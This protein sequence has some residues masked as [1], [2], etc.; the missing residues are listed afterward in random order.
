MHVFGHNIL[1]YALLAA[2]LRRRCLRHMERRCAPPSRRPSPQTRRLATSRRSTSCSVRS[3][4]ETFEL[5][6]GLVCGRQP[7]CCWRC[8]SPACG[9]ARRCCCR[10]PQFSLARLL[11]RH[12]PPHDHARLDQQHSTSG[13][14]P[15]H[16]RSA[17]C[18]R[19]SAAGARRAKPPSWTRC[20]NS[21][22]CPQLSATALQ[23]F[24]ACA[25]APNRRFCAPGH[26]LPTGRSPS[27]RM[28]DIAM[29]TPAK[30]AMRPARPEFSSGPCAKRPG[31]SPE[32]LRS[33]VLGRSHR[34]KLGKARL[35]AAIDQTRDGAAGPGR[36]PDRHRAG[37]RHRRG[38]DGACGRCSARCRCSCWP[39][40]ASARTG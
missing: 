35:K 18:W 27:A 6:T 36:L 21:E 12:G 39:S 15:V 33:A 37:L 4:T 20:A 16:R 25:E 17:P 34:S 5:A 32:N 14:S 9:S 24:P 8:A 22:R 19:S 7:S 1:V 30:P 13:A 10:P 28:G 3:R 11:S 31:W 26:A 40:R 38:R 2:E 23:N 29:N